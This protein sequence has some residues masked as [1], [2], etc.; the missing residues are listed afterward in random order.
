MDHAVEEGPEEDVCEHLAEES[1][2]EQLLP[3]AE[4]LLPV[5]ASLPQQ[6][7]PQGWTATRE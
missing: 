3:A 4:E 6:H 1:V 7:Q 2:G 5:V